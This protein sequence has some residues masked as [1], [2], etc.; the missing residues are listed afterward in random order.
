VRKFDEKNPKQLK[1]CK[2]VSFEN[3]AEAFFRPINKSVKTS[4]ELKTILKT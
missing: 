1:N 3:I 4:H 2:H